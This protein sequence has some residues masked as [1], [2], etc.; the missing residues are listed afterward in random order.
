[1]LAFKVS[2]GTGCLASL[3]LCPS[4]KVVLFPLKQSYVGGKRQDRHQVEVQSRCGWSVKRRG[5]K[6]GKKKN[7]EKSFTLQVAA[8]DSK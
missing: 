4:V 7:K 6:E 5:G 3:N 8:S 2:A 1:M